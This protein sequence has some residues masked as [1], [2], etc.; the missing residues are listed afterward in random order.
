MNLSHIWEQILKIFP[1]TL[2]E[3]RHIIVCEKVGKQQE[4][5]YLKEINVHFEL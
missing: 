2:D 3:E 1:A 4:S 5:M